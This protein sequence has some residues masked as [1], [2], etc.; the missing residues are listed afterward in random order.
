RIAALDAHIGDL[1]PGKAA[2][3]LVLERAHDDPWESVLRCDRSSVELVIIGGNFVYGRSDWIDALAPDGGTERLTT[4]GREMTL[5][6]TY[7]VHQPSTT[8]P[9][10]RELRAAILPHF[11][12]LGPIFA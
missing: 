12:Q 11:V 10:L 8:P 9:R 6:T 4:W 1:R 5:D 7:A 2:D 3:V